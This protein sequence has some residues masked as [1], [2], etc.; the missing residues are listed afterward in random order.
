MVLRTLVATAAL[1][2]SPLLSAAETGRLNLP[3]FTSLQAKAT[4]SVDISV[5]PFM[6]W[7]AT[8]FAPER[9][10]NGTE[11]KK[12]LQGINAVYVRSF[13][14]EEDDA[15]SKADI[16]SVRAQLRSQNWQPLAQIHSKKNNENVDIFIAIEN[17]KPAGFA[18]LASEPR[19]F[20]IVNVV[21]TID[22]ENIA[23]VQRNLDLPGSSGKRFTI[24]D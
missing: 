4:E 3:D 20:T 11:I 1:L 13:Q 21:G 2:S 9:D 5:G 18:I 22:P 6:L 16:E 24:E 14:F 17:D 7:L 8:T 19:E 23:K 10:E 12:I 15:Y